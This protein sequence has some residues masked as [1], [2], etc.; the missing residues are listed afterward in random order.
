MA[1]LFLGWHVFGEVELSG[2][3]AKVPMPDS[4]F[5]S[6]AGSRIDGRIAGRRPRSGMRRGLRSAAMG[7]SAEEE[8]DAVGGRSSAGVVSLPQTV[9]FKPIFARLPFSLVQER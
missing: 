6:R 3:W 9:T 8:G 2:R 4:T 5:T 7:R 1:L